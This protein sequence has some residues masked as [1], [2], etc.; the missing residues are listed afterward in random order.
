[1]HGEGVGAISGNVLLHEFLGQ[2]TS[3][4]YEESKLIH[5]MAS[6][7]AISIPHS[8]AQRKSVCRIA[9]ICHGLATG[10]L[11]PIDAVRGG[12]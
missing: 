2:D 5:R 9:H 10:H 4:G 6:C 12:R 3:R 1:M 11:K 8:I 7:Y